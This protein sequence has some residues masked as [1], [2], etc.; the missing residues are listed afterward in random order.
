M[1]EV[2]V[3]SNHLFNPNLI[4]FT[5][6]PL[7]LGEGRNISR[8]DLSIESHISK[9]TADAI[10]KLWFSGDFSPSKDGKDYIANDPS[11]NI[12]F[13][14]NLKFQTLLDSLAARSVAEVFIPITTNPQL[15]SWWFQHAFFEENIHSQSYADILKGLPVDAKSIFDDIMVNPAIIARAKSI[16]ACFEDTVT[17][18]AK[19]I[20]NTPDYSRE[21]HK[22]SI[23]KSLI[24]L[25]ILEAVLFKSSFLTSFAFKENGIY[26]VTADI[27]SKIAQDESG[28]YAMTINLINR[29]RKD[30]SWAY[31]FVEHSE[32]IDQLYKD[33]ITA[34]FDWI[35]YC[36]SNDVQLLGVNNKVLK[37]YV[38]ANLYS[39]MT[40]IGQPPIVDKL[41]NP[42][43]WANKYTRPSSIQTAQ[44]EKTSG[45][46]L[47]GIVKRD[48]TSA[49][50]ETLP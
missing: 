8:L 12:L 33:A 35:D 24:A 43:K 48:M 1:Q 38:T 31:I 47:L 14:K 49:M 4:D 7:F 16:V 13:M 3:M 23:V 20:L 45:N 39:V 5:Q 28:H 9:M 19:M 2:D 44:K 34:D 30:P 17:H 15:A 42:C 25:N 10:G 6:E 46:Y 29:L 11:L 22:V 32:T 27:I 26:S 36:Y 18:N 37:Q 41:D 50:W 21:L 40:S